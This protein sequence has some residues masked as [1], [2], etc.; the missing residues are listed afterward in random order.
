MEMTD[1]TKDLI[2]KVV[3]VSKTAV[4]WGFIPVVIWIGMSNCAVRYDVLVLCACMKFV[5]LVAMSLCC[6]WYALP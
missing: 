2:R 1:E 4:H 6:L 3:D 5:K